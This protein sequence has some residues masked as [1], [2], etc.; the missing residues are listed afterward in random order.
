MSS[1]NSS[2]GPHTEPLLLI[3]T[4]KQNA[5]KAISSLKGILE[6][7]NLDEEVNVTE[8]KE[9]HAWAEKHYFLINRQPFKEFMEVIGES[10]HASTTRDT[11]QDLYWLCQKYEADSYYYNAITTD[12]QTLQGIL[13][14]ILADG[15]VNDAEINNLGEWLSGNNHL[16]NYYPYD[17]IR[18]LVL[19]IVSDKVITEDEK[20]IFKAYV[21]QFVELTNPDIKARLQEEIHNVPISGICTSDPVVEFHGKKFCVTGIFTRQSRKEILNK[22]VALGGIVSSDVSSVTNY[23]IVADHGN[24]TWAFSCYGRKVEQAINLRKQGNSIMLINEY[25]FCDILDDKL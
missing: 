18:S 25:D 8:L 10:V 3:K 16:N 1:S 2:N 15:V 20:L 13:H 12:L 17:E 23:L 6:G 22:I 14:G 5:D 7:I 21:N 24:P 4:S 11:I 19:N 9:L